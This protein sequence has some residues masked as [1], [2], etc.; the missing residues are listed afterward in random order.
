MSRIAAQIQLATTFVV[1]GIMAS[2][3]I[4]TYDA[5]VPV[6]WPT[7]PVDSATR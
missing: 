2:V 1:G 6:E 5:P 7:G 3:M 4:L